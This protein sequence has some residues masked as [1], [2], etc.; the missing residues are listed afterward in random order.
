M[1]ERK[2][3]NKEFLVIKRRTLNRNREG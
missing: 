2:G 1:S 3:E